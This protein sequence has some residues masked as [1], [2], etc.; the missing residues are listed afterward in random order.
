MTI[1][2]LKCSGHGR[3]RFDVEGEKQTDFRR[4]SSRS[5]EGSG[6]KDQALRSQHPRFHIAQ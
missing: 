2:K 1:L 3:D 6:T 5:Q 4:K